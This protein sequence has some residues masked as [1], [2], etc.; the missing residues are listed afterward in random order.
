MATTNK[1]KKKKFR[2]QSNRS[3]AARAFRALKEYKPRTEADAAVSDLLTDLQHYCKTKEYDF[4]ELLRVAQGNF[5]YES[6]PTPLKQG[7]LVRI[8]ADVKDEGRITG[9][10]TVAQT[11]G[12][13]AKRVLVASES[14]R[15]TIFVRRDEVFAV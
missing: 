1:S 4:D 11:P 2:A 15:A 10:A 5:D 9:N 13:R 3:R 12:R 8:D 6:R 14:L 7:D